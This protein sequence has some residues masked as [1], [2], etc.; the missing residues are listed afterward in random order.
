MDEGP[1]IQ[2]LDQAQNDIGWEALL[3]GQVLTLWKEIKHQYFLFLGKRNLCERW[4]QLLI[5]KL[6]DVAWDQWEHKNEV[7]HQTKNLVTHTEAEQ[8][9]GWIREAIRTER[10]LISVGDQYLFR[11]IMVDLAFQWTLARKKQ[12]KRFVEIAW[13]G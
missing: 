4:V 10:R 8:L 2:K 7:V 1:E 12:W 6:F 3:N 9:N 5:Q 13:K 11:N